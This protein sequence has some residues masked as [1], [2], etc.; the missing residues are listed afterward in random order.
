MRMDSRR[1]DLSSHLPSIFDVNFRLDKTRQPRQRLF[2]NKSFFVTM[3]SLVATPAASS[4]FSSIISSFI[5][6]HQRS[7][8]TAS[9]LCQLRGKICFSYF[10]TAFESLRDYI[11][12]QRSALWKG[13]EVVAVDGMGLTL[14]RTKDL[15]KKG[16]NGRAVSKWRESYLPRGY[17]VMAYDVLLGVVREVL[18]NPTL[19]EVADAKSLIARLNPKTL[20][21]YDRLYF[22]KGLVLEH[23]NHGSYFVMRLRRNACK[24]VASFFSMKKSFHEITYG[25]VRI[26][27][28]KVK[29][30]KGQMV[31]A[32]N[33]S[34][35]SFTKEQLRD[36]YRLRWRIETAFKDFSTSLGLEAWHSK[37]ENGLLQ[38]L[39]LRLWMFN[40]SRLLSNSCQRLP[41]VG[42]HTYTLPCFRQ[43]L[44]YVRDNLHSY[45]K[46]IFKLTARVKEIASKTKQKREV[47]KRIYERVIRSPGTP[48]KRS[49]T[50]WMGDKVAA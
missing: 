36:L 12:T 37:T 5:T 23:K 25:G 49:S 18:L 50:E 21:L 16:Y 8:L 11:V 30:C 19:N 27:L 10:K 13:L 4:Y 35:D 20:F 2:S 46:D 31:Y 41:G 17:M 15:V 9:A 48:Y 1:F 33:L 44:Y 34:K 29:D 24:Q 38:E 40:L 32:T 22:S 47:Y 45:W 26:C 28:V 14:P 42:A 7:M 6:K 43:I 39:F 3:I